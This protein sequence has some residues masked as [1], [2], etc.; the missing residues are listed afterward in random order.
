MF[1]KNSL[2]FSPIATPMGF[3]ST[4]QCK[5]ACNGASGNAIAD[6]EEKNTDPSG[7]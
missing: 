3:C 5:K 4:S 1:E 7:E 2:L 6:V